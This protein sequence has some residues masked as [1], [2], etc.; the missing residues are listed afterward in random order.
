MS[1]RVLVID[2]EFALA[3]L[4]CDLLAME[5][6]LTAVALNGRQGLARLGESGADLVL[7]DVMMPIMDGPSTLLAMRAD[8]RFAAIPVV[9]M[10]AAPGALAR[11]DRSLYQEALRKPFTP[12]ALFGLVARL[13]G[14]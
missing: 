2:D 3:E 12:E 11:V 10:T 14:G 5:G 1:K 6:H 7:L 13:L 9:M 4:V 8:P